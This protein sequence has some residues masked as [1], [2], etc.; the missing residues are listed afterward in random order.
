ML[1]LVLDLFGVAPAAQQ[2]EAKATP[3]LDGCAQAAPQ[4]IAKEPAVSLD[5]ALAPAQFTHPRANRA[6]HFAHARVHYEFQRGQ[7]RT[8]G[9]SVGADGLAVRA[10]RW[11]PLHEVEAALREKERWIVAK[12]GEARARH[13]RIESNRIAWRDGAT[14]PF[15]GQP[16]TLVLDPRQ[17]HGRGGA[18][19]AESDGARV[20]HIGL[21]H[22]AT[23]D[24]LRD[25]AQAWLMRQARRVFTARLDH[26]APRLSVRWQRLSLSSAGTRWGSASADGSIRLN[27]RLIHFREPIIDYVVVHELA[28]LREMNHGPRFWQHVQSVLPDYAERRVQLKDEAVPRW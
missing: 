5:D 25:T 10:P 4:L 20:L 3:A 12:L 13:E 17:R 24:Q 14:L 26:F 15:L 7:R 21:P 1:Q 28:H 2:S 16:V 6:I 27:W 8:I 22:S 19:L 23:P 18:V 11:T 9:F